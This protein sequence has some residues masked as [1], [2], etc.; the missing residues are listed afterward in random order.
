[1]KPWWKQRSAAAGMVLAVALA[2]TA[3]A[4]QQ[5]FGEPREFT[6]IPTEGFDY[7]RGAPTSDDDWRLAPSF[8]RYDAA[9]E[10]AA[11][12]GWFEGYPDGSFRPE[13]KLTAE[14]LVRV[15]ER[16]FPDGIT[17]A[18]AAALLQYGEWGADLTP[19]R[20][21][22]NPI[23]KGSTWRMGGWDVTVRQ[24]E[25]APVGDFSVRPSSS[26]PG[27]SGNYY[28]VELEV[29]WRGS[30]PA[31]R[32]DLDTYLSFGLMDV[33]DCEADPVL[34]DVTVGTQPGEP[35]VG[36]LCWQ[37]PEVPPDTLFFAALPPDP[38]FY[39]GDILN[40][41]ENPYGHGALPPY[42]AWMSLK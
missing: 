21:R 36:N 15:I 40:E 4:Q 41:H 5:L 31:P 37:L 32:F 12:R 27:I 42:W 9:V 13:A 30:G 22:T 2:G 19:G 25:T 20:W 39:A 11:R 23:P 29:V 16:A 33:G 7:R 26:F 34:P 24:V 18:Q 38:K 10:H 28:I 8:S 17:R 1:M 35:V 14:Q 6:D 3:A